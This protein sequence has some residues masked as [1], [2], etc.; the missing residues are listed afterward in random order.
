MRDLVQFLQDLV[1]RVHCMI[2]LVQVLQD[3]V[4]RV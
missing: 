2:D 3:L 4:P 1:P